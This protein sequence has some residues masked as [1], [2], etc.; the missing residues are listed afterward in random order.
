[1][2]RGEKTR[3]RILD[4]A[5]ECFAAR[6]YEG[7]TV[8]EICRGAGVNVASVNYFFGSKEKLY[9]EVFGRVIGMTVGP[10]LHLADGVRDP[11]SWH[12]AIRTWAASMLG[13]VMGER[14]PQSWATRL[15]ARE[16]AAPS[17]SLA[18]IHERF[19]AGINRELHRLIRMAFPRDPGEEVVRNWAE[20]VFGQVLLYAFRAPPWDRILGIPP[21]AAREA[22]IRRKAEFIAGG[23][24][25]RLRFRRFVPA[26]RVSR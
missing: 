2:E 1:M 8:R 7:A 5:A 24:T 18:H 15:F 17:A 20:L 26:G 19:M 4:A 9:V 3:S 16:R 25:S 22:W 23:I 11:E 12:C 21:A 14:P 13:A 10:L 6:G